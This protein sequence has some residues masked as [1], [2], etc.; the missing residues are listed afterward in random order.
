MK[1]KMIVVFALGTLL[2]TPALAQQ[3]TQPAHGSGPYASVGAQT[4]WSADA[5]T[6]FELSRDKAANRN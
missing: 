4:D 2:A 3:T 6:R 5:N 1:S